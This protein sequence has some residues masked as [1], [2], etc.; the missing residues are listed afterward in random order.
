MSLRNTLW[1]LAATTYNKFQQVILPYT[2]ASG[3]SHFHSNTRTISQ[4]DMKIVIIPA[5]SDNYMY[6]VIDEATKQAGIVDPVDPDRVL[7]ALKDED[8]KLTSILTTHHHWDH[9]GGNEN[10]VKKV[11]GLKVYG[12]DD[13]IGALNNKVSH[14]DEFK[15]GN[16]NVRCLFTPCHT[17]GHICYYVTGE[18][19]EEPSVFTGDTLFIAGC[20]R[21]FEGNPEQMHEALVKIL[22]NLPDHTKVYCGHEYTVNNLKFALQVEPSNA[23]IKEKM[24]WAESKRTENEPTVPSTIAEEKQYNPFMRVGQSS[25]QKHA[26]TDD[27][28]ATMAFIR[29]EK[30]NFKA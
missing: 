2:L 10:M 15:I 8:V 26:G 6:L 18:S 30:D 16:L 22:G 19:G 17:S 13:R 28:V 9:A 27:S 20:G 25:V 1:R 12:G 11:S 5:L 29:K 21:F 7:T 14:D 4:K 23:A 24:S 3:A